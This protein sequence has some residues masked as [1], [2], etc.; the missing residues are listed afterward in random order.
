MTAGPPARTGPPAWPPP[1]RALDRA[2]REGRRAALL[3]TAPSETAEPPRVLGPMPA[4]DLRSRLAALRPKPWAP[5]HAAALA[6]LQ[7]WRSANPGAFASLLVSDGIEHAPAT[8]APAA[9]RRWPP[10]DR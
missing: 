5:D 10:P 6:A 8:A 3:A 4:E 7:A 1:P 9:R 2:G